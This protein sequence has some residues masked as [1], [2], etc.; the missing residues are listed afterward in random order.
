MNVG[1]ERVIERIKDLVLAKKL[2]GI[3]DITDLTDGG[4]VE[5]LMHPEWANIRLTL[6]GYWT[7]TSARSS[8]NSDDMPA[9]LYGPTGHTTRPNIMVPFGVRARL[10]LGSESVF[11][12]LEPAV[13]VE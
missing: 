6:S 1:P 10:S 3:S 12:L 8:A 5:D 9:R 7:F 11:E 4:P 13:T 2:E